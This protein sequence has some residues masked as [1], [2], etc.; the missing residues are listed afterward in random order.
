MAPTLPARI[1]GVGALL[2]VGDT[3]RVPELRHEVPLAIADPFLFVEVDGTRHVVISVIDLD[4]VRELG[5]VEA[6]PLEEFGY[7]ELLAQG[8]PIDVVRREV[9][10]NACRRLGVSSASVPG[11]FPLAVADRLRDAGVVLAVDQGVFDDRRRVK[12][13]AELAGIRRAQHAAE[14]GMRACV[15]LFRRAGR[16]NGSLVLGDEVLTVELVKQHVEEVFVGHGVTADEFI[17][18][19]GPQGAIGHDMGSGPIHTGESIIVDLWPR[20]RDSACFADMTRTFVVG[21][22]P[23]DLRELHRL[24]REALELAVSMVRPGVAGNDVYGAV[25]ERFEAAGYPTARSKEPGTVLLEGFFHGLGH[26]VGLDVHERPGISRYSDD[27]VEGDVI[28]LEPGLYRKGYGGVR[29]ED[30]L[31]VT[32]DGAENLTDFPYDLEVDP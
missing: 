20:D 19:R 25:C 16:H 11:G 8:L 10:V 4:R 22:V 3:V 13:A 2:V 31:L 18:A 32:A 6:H 5:G 28:T 15:D 27:L 7:D 26:G 23:D 30:L 1:D 24:T 14:V 17:V 12:S 21:D 9:C 29:L